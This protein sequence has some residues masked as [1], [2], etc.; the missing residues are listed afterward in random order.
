MNA[1]LEILETRIASKLA[2][3]RRGDWIC[4]SC[5][6]SLRIARRYHTQRLL[7]QAVHDPLTS[8]HETSE[9]ERYDHT[10]GTRIK[11]L[12]STEQWK[13]AYRQ[14][15]RPLQEVTALGLQNAED[16]AKALNLKDSQLVFKALLEHQNDPDYFA[17][18]TAS[19]WTEIWRVLN[20]QKVFA[21]LH[22]IHRSL[23]LETLEGLPRRAFNYKKER[24][25]YMK[26]IADL[27]NI[28]RRHG[29][30]MDIIDYRTLLTYVARIGDEPGARMIWSE[31][32]TE[33]IRPDRD[34]YNRFMEA[35]VWDEDA[36]ERQARKAKD[37]VGRERPQFTDIVL[38]KP[39]KSV[40]ITALFNEMA[41]YKIAP[42]TATMCVLMTALARDGEFTEAT[43]ILK[44]VWTV[45]VEALV[46]G[47]EISNLKRIYEP[48]APLFPTF[49]LFVTIAEVFGLA[50]EVPAGFRV[51]DYLAAQYNLPLPENVWYQIVRWAWLQARLRPHERRI[52]TGTQINVQTVD[53][54]LEIL[55]SETYSIEHSMD[56]YDLKFKTLLDSPY[57]FDHRF[58]PSRFVEILRLGSRKVNE[59][60]NEL[61]RL[62][63][64]AR[65]ST[66]LHKAGA[67]TTGY[68]VNKVKAEMAHFQ[69]RKQQSILGIW[70]KRLIA[71]PRSKLGKQDHILRARDY[72]V[73]VEDWRSAGFTNLT[74]WRLRGFQ[75]FVWDHRAFVP[76]TLKYTTDTGIVELQF[77]S[78][79]PQNRECQEEKRPAIETKK[80]VRQ[81]R[82][83]RPLKT[84]HLASATE[85]I[86]NVELKKRNTTLSSNIARRRGRSKMSKR[87]RS[88]MSKDES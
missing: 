45:D 70:M 50:N 28:R 87:G 74:E 85:P 59:S 23:N 58:E 34:C 76:E 78:A 11:D 51:L 31:M 72:A 71:L 77:E 66:A 64:R 44:R 40:E 56:L 25:R 65:D 6:S 55:A 69:Y 36:R 22:R 15:L 62:V 8:R 1:W 43:K 2:S 27:I 46:N 68:N 33:G 10:K 86:L 49:R 24:D 39:G 42:D 30:A 3:R 67:V 5:L 7:R 82:S 79:D 9:A 84:V 75:N 38:F 18:I 4:P 41:T 53:R 37:T 29:P 35:M 52:G 12:A 13:D 26:D 57:A 88:K 81:K 48:S 61:S 47:D 60:K 83:L 16:L 73:D 19:T 63:A 17:S 14:S 32:K 80:R 54:L 21:P 20:P